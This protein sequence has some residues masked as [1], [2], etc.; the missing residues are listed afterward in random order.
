MLSQLQTKKL[1]RVCACVCMSKFGLG[2]RLQFLQKLRLTT[3][4]LEQQSVDGVQAS[5]IVGVK[6]GDQPFLCGG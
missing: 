1:G 5:L 3:A 2:G 4:V 6:E